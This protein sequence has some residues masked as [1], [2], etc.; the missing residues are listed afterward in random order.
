M[1]T[2]GLVEVEE[3]DVKNRIDQCGEHAEAASAPAD[4]VL[5]TRSDLA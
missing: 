2:Q 1:H 3:M 4:A 5:G